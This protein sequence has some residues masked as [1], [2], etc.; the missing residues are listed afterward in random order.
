MLRRKRFLLNLDGQL[1]LFEFGFPE[2]LEPYPPKTV[3]YGDELWR[4]CHFLPCLVRDKPRPLAGEHLFADQWCYLPVSFFDTQIPS[5]E[6]S[7]LSQ[8]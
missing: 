8:D 3:F 7:G 4:R 5:P 6:A 1:E 2:G